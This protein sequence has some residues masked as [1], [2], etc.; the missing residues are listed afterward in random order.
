[1][2][3]HNVFSVREHGLNRTILSSAA[4]AG[5]AYMGF[6]LIKLVNYWNKGEVSDMGT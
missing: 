1:M 5:A 6:R 4:L 2:D 3:H